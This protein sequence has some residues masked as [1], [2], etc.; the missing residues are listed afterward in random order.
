M[1]T[2][3]KAVS[4]GPEKLFQIWGL[5]TGAQ[6]VVNDISAGDHLLLLESEDFK[7]FGEVVHYFSEACWDLSSYIWG[8][9]KFALIVLLTGT[10]IEYPWDRFRADFGFASNYHMR[11]NTMKLAQS[12]IAS[13][14]FEG[15]GAFIRHLLQ[16]RATPEA[17]R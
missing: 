15:E 16:P 3:E 11:G 7:Y 1:D 9:Q 17:F 5:P 4:A 6:R 14:R 10:L 2:V 13:S 8:E 12:K